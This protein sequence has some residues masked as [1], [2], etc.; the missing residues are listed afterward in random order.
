MT[1]RAYILLHVTKGKSDL[2]AQV[3]R[4]QNGVRVLDVLE[5]P[6]DLVLMM[7][8]SGRERLA[9][10]TIQALTSVEPMTEGLQVLPSRPNWSRV[11]P[12]L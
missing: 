11:E 2:V 1:A 3:L 10:L 9:E 6:P 4:A 5:G 8:A 12:L 7:E